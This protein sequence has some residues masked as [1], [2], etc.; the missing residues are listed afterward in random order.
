M[1]A[2]FL[3]LDS[4]IRKQFKRES[5]SDFVTEKKTR[6][7]INKK[8]KKTTKLTEK[9]KTP[10]EVTKRKTPSIAIERKQISNK[11]QN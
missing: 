7:S 11:Q 2:K 5:K 3:R 1:W 4:S 10:D 8:K 6:S 9:K